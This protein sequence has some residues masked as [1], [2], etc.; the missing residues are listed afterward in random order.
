MDKTNPMQL[1]CKDSS[2][3]STAND[4]SAKAKPM[5]AM[6]NDTTP[7]GSMAI[8]ICIFSAKKLKMEMES[9]RTISI[10]LASSLPM[11]VSI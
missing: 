10:W 7:N 4:H 6:A 8:S 9:P 2:G 1:S 11:M 5:V 3:F